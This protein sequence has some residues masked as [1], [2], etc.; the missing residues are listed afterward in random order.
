MNILEYPENK[1][2]SSTQLQVW[3]NAA[4]DGEDLT[5]KTSWSSDCTKENLR[6]ASLNS[7]PKSSKPVSKKTSKSLT[8][9]LE[10]A[11]LKIATEKR[12][13]GKVVAA[14]FM[15]PKRNVVVSKKVEEATPKPSAK[16]SWRRG[17]SLG[18]AEI[19][20]RVPPATIPGP[21]TTQN[22]RKSFFWKPPLEADEERRKTIGSRKYVKK[23][24]ET[25]ALVVQPRN[26]FKEGETEKSLTMSS[27]KKVLKPGRVVAS[28]YN[29]CSGNSGAVDVRKR[30]FPENNKGG[31]EVRMKKRW[32]IPAEEVSGVV[33]LPKIRTL[34]CVNESPRDSGAAKRVAELTGKRSYFCN[35]EEGVEGSVCQVLSFAEE[36]NGEEG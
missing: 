23:K 14:K 6:P 3:N 16:V 18:P 29:Q 10:K 17:M 26:L 22:R 13:R 30:S 35:E 12:V 2:N 4:F 19:A 1:N 8:L 21:A 31:S 32:E 25:A 28:R 15:E 33:M 9:R 20:A 34:R 5:M 11:E 27:S 36:D 24:E 7:S